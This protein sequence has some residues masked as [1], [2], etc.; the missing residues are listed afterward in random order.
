MLRA[1]CKDLLFARQRCPLPPLPHVVQQPFLDARCLLRPPPLAGHR[2]PLRESRTELPD[3]VR[4][5]PR[6]VAGKIWNSGTG[7]SLS[8][9]PVCVENYWLSVRFPNQVP[10]SPFRQQ[11]MRGPQRGTNFKLKV[12]SR[13][14]SQGSPIVTSI[15]KFQICRDRGFWIRE[16]TGFSGISPVRS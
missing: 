7:T 13:S 5:N 8:K 4:R 15:P 10:D 1:K 16:F 2:L 9:F 12:Q 11:G 6:I 3:P 14:K